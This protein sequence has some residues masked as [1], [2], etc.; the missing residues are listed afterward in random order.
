MLGDGF[1]GTRPTLTAAPGAPGALLV[2]T[3]LGADAEGKHGQA[4]PVCIA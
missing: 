2:L 3:L 4:G 1:P